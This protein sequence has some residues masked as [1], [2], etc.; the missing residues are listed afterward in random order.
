M[1]ADSWEGADPAPAVDGRCAPRFHLV[2]E[3]FADV[4]ASGRAGSALAIWHDG[5][6]VV[7][8]WGG[9]AGCGSGRRWARDTLVMPYS[10]SKPF[11][12]VCA[13][14]LVQ[15]GLL[16]LDVPARRYWPELACDASVRQILDHT[17]GLVLLDEPAP[18]SA[19]FDWSE[20]CPLGP[21]TS[22]VDTGQ[23]RGGVRAVLRPPGR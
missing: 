2:G 19:F 17:A 16:V 20:L 11:A 13:L 8:L 23:R 12:A 15:R 4:V 7:D 14:L 3:A 21:A 9:R 6:M 22:G 1:R 5:R 18:T 10:V